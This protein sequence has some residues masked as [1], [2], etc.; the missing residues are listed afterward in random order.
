[1]SEKRNPRT[2]IPRRIYKSTIERIDKHLESFPRKTKTS[3][4]GYIKANFNQF[5]EFLLDT[6]EGVQKAEK[7]Y[8]VDGFNNLEEARGKAIEKAVAS[9]KPVKWPIIAIEVGKDGE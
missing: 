4:R 6:Y 1:M 9:K 7:V 3:T 8:V 2:D 5:L